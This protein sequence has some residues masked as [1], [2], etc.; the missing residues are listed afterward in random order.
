MAS[1]ISFSL[2]PSQIPSATGRSISPAF[3]P[4]WLNTRAKSLWRNSR[5]NPSR[6]IP[7]KGR[8]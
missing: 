7:R 2:I 6:G 3:F 5:P 4:S 1:H 8:W